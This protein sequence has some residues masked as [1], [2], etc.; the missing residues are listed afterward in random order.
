MLFLRAWYLNVFKTVREQFQKLCFNKI[1]RINKILDEKLG[2]KK[3][4]R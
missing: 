4:E 2:K 3:V 1:H